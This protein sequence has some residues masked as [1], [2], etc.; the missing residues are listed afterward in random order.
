MT[1]QEIIRSSATKLRD[2]AGDLAIKEAQVLVGHVFN[3]SRG[4]MITRPNMALGGEKTS[5]LSDLIKR[6]QQGESIAKITGYK[7][8]W[9]LSFKVTKDTLDPR[10]DTEVLIEAVLEYSKDRTKAYRILDLGTGTG[11]LVLS[12]LH[13]IENSQG[14]AVDISSAALKVM[15]ENAKNLGLDNRAQLVQSDWGAKVE[16]VFDII[17]SNP[18][19]ISEIEYTNLDFTVRLSD[20]KQALVSGQSGYE[21]YEQIAPFIQKHLARGG[22]FAIEI[23]INQEERVLNILEEHNLIILEI[24]K[25]LSGIPRCIVGQL[26]NS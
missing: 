19:Y 1:V 8:F 16:G 14:V 13:E 23:G 21:A 18:P 2:I 17:V 9:S 10:P 11:C 5:Q 22:F 3:I 25:D 15:E 6:R 20:P 26:D 24:R 12:L 4:D 7:E